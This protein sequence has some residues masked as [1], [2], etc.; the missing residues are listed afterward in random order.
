MTTTSEEKREITPAEERELERKFYDAQPLHTECMFC[1]WDFDGP[2]SSTRIAA[3]E[4]RQ[5]KHP[6]TL[7]KRRSKL[8][9]RTL[10]SFRSL[11]I[12]SRDK[13]EVERERKRRAF[14]IGVDLEE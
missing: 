1:D 2:A 7:N 3:F 10:T 9:R 13:E 11:E 12:D 8:R 4:H 5:E 6:E 14:L